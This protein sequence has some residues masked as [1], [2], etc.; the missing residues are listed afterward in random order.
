MISR[1][2]C[3]YCGGYEYVEGK[4][5][6]YSAISP[7]DKVLTFK[8]QSLYHQICLNCGAI[9]KSYVKNPRKL[10]TKKKKRDVEMF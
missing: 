8:S 9:V 2:R 7:A 3:P 10:V 1:E 5:D 6:G 4:Q